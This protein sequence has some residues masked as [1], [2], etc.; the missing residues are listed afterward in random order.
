[1]EGVCCH[2]GRLPVGLPLK[3]CLCSA[4][5]DRPSDPERALQKPAGTDS[6]EGRA[7]RGMRASDAVLCAAGAVCAAGDRGR[8]RGEYKRGRADGLYSGTASVLCMDS[9]KKYAPD[10]SLVCSGRAVFG[11][12]GASGAGFV[13]LASLRRVRGRDSHSGAVILQKKAGRPAEGMDIPAVRGGGG[14]RLDLHVYCVH[15]AGE[16]VY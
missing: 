10:A 14:S 5:P 12:S 13:P 6:D 7:D 9:H 1:M 15:N 11:A 3:G 16:Y 2:A 8:E 4:S